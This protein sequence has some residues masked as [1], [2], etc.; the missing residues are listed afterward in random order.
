V[1]Q[2]TNKIQSRTLPQK[3]HAYKRAQVVPASLLI[4]HASFP[5]Q[6]AHL[7][8][9]LRADYPAAEGQRLQSVLH[10]T[11][12]VCLRKAIYLVKVDA[13]KSSMSHVVILLNLLP[14][15]H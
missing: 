8:A 12:Q 13:M 9:L 7:A 4:R 6:Q 1:N 2:S 11:A 5:G 15:Q 10:L 3:C 14:A